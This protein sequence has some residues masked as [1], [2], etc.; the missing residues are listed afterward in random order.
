MYETLQL[1][2]IG[3][4]VKILQEKLKRLDY[5]NALIT[6]SFGLSLEAG[7]RA[8]Q[9]DNQ[10]PITGIV[11]D[12]TWEI[13]NNYT[14]SKISPISVYPTL[15][16]GSSG[17]F[18]TDL[19][20]KLKA[21]LYY[22]GDVNGNFDLETELSVKRFQLNNEITASGTVNNETWN[23]LNTLYG[24][25]RDCAIDGEDIDDY[26]TYTVQNGD[27]IFMVNN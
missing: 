21:L 10:L 23:L 16:L 20:T 14:E 25:L 4:D 22:T 2:D 5:Y 8:F 19:Q 9:K 12:E 1:G 27:R 3:D 18:V 6:G 15:S 26:T 17:N 24:N 7:V 13:L 11:D